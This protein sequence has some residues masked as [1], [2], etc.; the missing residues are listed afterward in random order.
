M[1]IQINFWIDGKKPVILDNV[2]G[3]TLLSGNVH[4]RFTD[5]TKDMCFFDVLGIIPHYYNEG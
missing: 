2:K 4:V 3:I 5:G 1:S